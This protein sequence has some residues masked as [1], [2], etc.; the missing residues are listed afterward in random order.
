MIGA[1]PKESAKTSERSVALESAP[2]SAH[3]PVSGS[4]APTGTRPAGPDIHRLELNRDALLRTWDSYSN[5]NA[6]VDALFHIYRPMLARISGPFLR[7]CLK[8]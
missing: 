5:P 4:P 2:P 1:I 3:Y 6:R 8:A 7:V